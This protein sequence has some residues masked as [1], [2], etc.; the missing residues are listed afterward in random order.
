MPRERGSCRG[1]EFHSLQ[2]LKVR[3]APRGLF[4]EFDDVGAVVDADGTELAQDVLAEEA[5]KLG[6]DALREIV[7]IHDRDRLGKQKPAANF[8]VHARAQRIAY[9]A[10]PADGL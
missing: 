7:Q 3:V 8:Q 10:G 2:S 9:D 6:P 1:H 4:F 5:V